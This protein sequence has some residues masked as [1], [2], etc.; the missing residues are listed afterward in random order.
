MA[1][2]KNTVVVR[3]YG[4]RAPLDWDQDVHEQLFLQNRFWNRLVEIDQEYNLIL[5]EFIQQDDAIAALTAEVA[6]LYQAKAKVRKER[7]E[8]RAKAQKKVATPMLDKDL[9]TWAILIKSERVELKRLRKQ[10]FAENKVAVKEIEDARKAAVR[11]ARQN[12]NDGLWDENPEI[13]ALRVER[14]MLLEQLKRAKEQSDPDAREQFKQQTRVLAK[15]IDARV[16][17]D[18]PDPRPEQALYWGNANAVCDSHRTARS[19][20]MKTGAQLRFHRFDGAGRFTNQ[21][22]GGMSVGKLFGARHSQV[23]ADPLP[24]HEWSRRKCARTTLRFCI[25]RDG[26]D[27]RYLTFPMIVHRAL[28]EHGSI[29]LVTLNRTK[30]GTHWL[31][32]AVFT[33]VAEL[34]VPV[35]TGTHA[36]GI[37]I[38]WRKVKNGLRV[39]TIY[40]TDSERPWYVVLPQRIMDDLNRYDEIQSDLKTQ[41]NEVHSCLKNAELA[42][43]PAQLAERLKKIRTA[44]VIGAAKLAM[45]AI[46]WR[47]CPDYRPKVLKQLEAW[48][49]RDRR[50]R[51]AAAFLRRKC[52]ARRRTLYEAVTKQLSER[53]AVIGIERFNLALTK[54]RE[55]SDGTSN[56]LPTPA[57]VQRD[58]GAPGLL[59]LWTQQQAAKTGAT[60]VEITGKTTM[61]CRQCGVVNHPHDRAALVWKC[62]GCGD[63]WDQ[64]VNASKNILD[65]TVGH[66]GKPVD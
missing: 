43:P 42:L 24:T 4:L 45:L 62:E 48:R 25:Y 29:K 49:K 44:P 8:L 65:I 21:I 1:E 31:W 54:R 3:R 64:D 56:P 46:T 66:N 11:L 51:D 23:R 36:C 60:I 39:A 9:A 50:V 47:E 40:G 26:G 12:A 61:T 15:Q 14:S 16:R 38:G 13:D 17:A 2:L 10:W 30:A 34:P 63:V 35:H 33:C 19:R 59:R 22:Q 6:E 28:P 5:A 18:N 41:L 7:S 53:Y 52:L 27:V 20:V 57:R 37:D 32:H 58:R 55:A